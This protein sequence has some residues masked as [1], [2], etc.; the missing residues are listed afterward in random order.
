MKKAIFDKPNKMH[1]ESGFRAFDDAVDYIGS[2]NVISNVQHSSFVRPWGEL[3]VM[4]YK[5]GKPTYSNP[6]DGRNFDLKAFSGIPPYVRDYIMD[7]ENRDREMILYHFRFYNR[8]RKA[9]DTI[10]WGVTDGKT[11]KRLLGCCYNCARPKRVAAFTECMKYVS[12]E[13]A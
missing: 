8:V 5:D 2:G 7:A 12:E 3:T 6:G 10:G 4:G 11:H 9:W 1:F 13:A